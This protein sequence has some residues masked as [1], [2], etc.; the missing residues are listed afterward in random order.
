MYNI[1]KTCCFTGHR[2]Q[3]LPCGFN[4]K[5]KFCVDIKKQ[6]KT[7]IIS[8]IKNEGVSHFISGGALGVDMW[9]M[10]IVLALKNKYDITLEAAIPCEGQSKKWNE[11][12]QKRYNYLIDR[13]DKITLVQ[14]EYTSDCMMKRNKYM[15]DNSTYIIAVWNGKCSGTSKTI[16]YAKD[17]CR[18]VFCIDIENI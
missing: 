6:L 12:L 3:N 4:E 15:V 2:P 18:Q 9:A 5:H 7:M 8:M 16:R 10:E 1:E 11:E 17:K 13:C 14:K